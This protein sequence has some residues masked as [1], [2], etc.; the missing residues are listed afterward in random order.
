VQEKQPCDKVDVLY[1]CVSDECG[2]G[3]VVIV[4]SAMGIYRSCMIV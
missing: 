2:K 4:L 1:M 3:V